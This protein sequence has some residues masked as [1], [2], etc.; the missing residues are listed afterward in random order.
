M[1]PPQSLDIQ[2]KTLQ[3]LP[4]RMIDIDRM[5]SRLV[6]PVENPDTPAGLGSCREYSQSE[7][8]LVDYLRTAVCEYQPFR[9]NFGDCGCIESLVCPQSILE[10]TTVLCKCRWIHYHQ[11][12]FPLRT[13]LQE[14]Q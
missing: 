8:L 3:I 11:V 12:I 2:K 14:I 6:Q 1:P 9:R 10:H 5:V 7:S 4:F 13:L